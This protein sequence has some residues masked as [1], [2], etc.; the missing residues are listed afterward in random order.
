MSDAATPI[1]PPTEAGNRPIPI[2]LGEVAFGPLLSDVDVT[3]TARGL[4][5]Q[6]QISGPFALIF[7]VL[8]R[9]LA[10]ADGGCSKRRIVLCAVLSGVEDGVGVEAFAEE[11]E[12]RLRGFLELPNGIPSHDTL[13]DVLG[14]I[15]PAAWQ[16]AFT[17]WAT[18]A[19]PV[20]EDAGRTRND[21]PGCT[22]AYTG[23]QPSGR[24]V[25][26]LSSAPDSKLRMLER[27]RQISRMTMARMATL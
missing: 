15:D 27:C 26:I 24:S 18:A 2:R 12:A 17:A 23:H 1:T 7:S 11:K 22:P 20:G 3:P 19:A 21:C 25:P 16:T 9:W 10:R 4:D 14:R 6:K 13:S 8:A 5:E